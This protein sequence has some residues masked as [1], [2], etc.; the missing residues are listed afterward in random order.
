MKKLLLTGIFSVFL[1]GYLFAQS[2]T[3][4][5]T[6][7]SS[8]DKATLP[9][10]NV[11]A[12]G[13]NVGVVTDIE[14]KYKLSVPAGVTKLVFTF[15]GFVTQEVEIGNREMID[16]ALEADTKQLSEV[17]VVG[18]GTQKKA[19][20]TG[21][22]AS[23]SGK[24]VQNLPVTSF[25]GALQ[26]RAAGVFI[27]QGNGKL[28]QAMKMR[29]RGASSVSAS[30]QPLFVIDGIPVTSQSQS[31]SGADTNPLADLNFNDVES[32]EVLKDAASAAIYGARAAN[33]VVL[34]TTKKGKAGKTKVSI[35]ALSGVSN[36]TRRREFLNAEQYLSFYT[37]ALTNAGFD[38]AEID[39][40]FGF[41]AVDTDF[42]KREV[43]TNWQN[44]IFK[45]NAGF[46]Q[47]DVSLNGGTDKTKFYLSTSSLDQ[48]GI[49]VGNRFQRQ[50][51]RLNLDHSITD[52]LKIG[53]NMN[54]VRSYNR[55]LA[56]DNEFSSPMQIVALPP[57]T[58]VRK[59]TGQLVDETD[60]LPYY[61]PLVELENAYYKTT[62]FRTFTN[63]YLSYEITK[64]LTARGE[65]G[66]DMLNQNEDRF[67]GTVTQAGRGAGGTGVGTSRI[68]Q[69]LNYTTK[70]YL[71]YNKT[72]SKHAIDITGG[73]E[74]QRS[75]TDRTESQGQGITV[76]QLQKLVSAPK[77]TSGSSELTGF[78]FL[79]YFARANYKFNNRYLVSATVRYDGSTRFGETNRFGTFP[80][81]SAGWIISEE[82]FM[83]SIK[84][85]LSFLKIKGSYGLTGNA[86]IG[87]FS[88]LPLYNGVGYAEIG[89]IR[90]NQLGNP[91]LKWEKTTQV[92]LGLEFGLFEDRISGDVTYFQ[93]DTRD[94]LLNIPIAGTN[95]F[96]TQFKNIGA[97]KNWGWE[98]GINSNN[99]VGELKWNTSLNMTFPQNQV[100]DLGGLPIIDTGGSRY[101][102]VAQVGQPIGA[103]L[104]VEYR[105][106]DPKNGDALYDL[107]DGSGATTTS[108]N[109]AFRNAKIL[110]NPNPTFYG[111]ITNNFSYKGFDLSIFFQWVSG[112]QIH[113][114]AG[115]FMSSSGY[116]EDNQTTDQLRRWQKEG[117]ITDI[118]KATYFGGNGF[119]GRI[120]R[121]LSDGSYLRLKT[122]TLGYNV[123]SNFLKKIS[124]E[125]VRFYVTGQNLLTFTK[126]T[127]W[128]PEV[129]TDFL[130]T[131]I[132]QGVDFYAAPQS[133]TVTIG[134][135]IGF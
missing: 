71:N 4:S 107:N 83:K 96:A 19:D 117:D 122:L 74:F 17:V 65:F 23:V 103:F 44:E 24:E 62:S 32:F 12:K 40:F 63:S 77:I 16:L 11:V 52:K 73:M 54:F 20:I 113:N 8:E 10:V 126:Y 30:N 35:N 125:T 79:S 76:D 89:G 34:I 100:T 119:A 123:P 59:K 41:Y 93:K 98:I 13:T 66:F 72:L 87:N 53:L 26:G 120:S 15:V 36:P 27:E 31:G 21:N 106:V 46:N 22:I 84:P 131:N 55:R 108:F 1:L 18:Y 6:V 88:Q 5:G 37:E 129:N 114:A 33:G 104:G 70:A 94:L 9:G 14:G 38:Q 132:F 47:L 124:L 134:L 80:S 29:I 58:P 56:P 101:M 111:G 48:N 69:V 92:D 82:G 135:N 7:T 133:K 39:D 45:K 78:A 75:Q 127:G 116:Y 57:I 68:V 43:E 99:L 95:G 128:D 51:I 115:L 64:G 86:E 90:P 50:S 97:M 49:L 110:G 60:G 61:N 91:N 28:G 130:A 118:P 109:T 67:Q 42:K 25:E 105:G 112:N 121:H 81:I 2:R 3:I 102:N 85:T